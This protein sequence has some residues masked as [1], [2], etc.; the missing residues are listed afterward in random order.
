MKI[1]YCRIVYHSLY[2]LSSKNLHKCYYVISLLYFAFNYR[3]NYFIIEKNYYFECIC[4]ITFINLAQ[5][6]NDFYFPSKSYFLFL[7]DS[8]N[9]IQIFFYNDLTLAIMLL[10][11]FLSLCLFYP[12]FTIYFHQFVL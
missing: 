5:S 6:S 3:S 9:F 7:L 1:Y 10:I 12:Y 8:L 2:Y 4:S 11:Y